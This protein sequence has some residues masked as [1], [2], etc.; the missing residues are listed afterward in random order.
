MPG[1]CPA[2]GRKK[3][4]ARASSL[5]GLDD[6]T[7]ISFRVFAHLASLLIVT[8]L[9]GVLSWLGGAIVIRACQGRSICAFSRPFRRSAQQLPAMSI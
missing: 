1:I 9:G 5:A 3:A 2:C 4:Y 6:R 7:V 8:S